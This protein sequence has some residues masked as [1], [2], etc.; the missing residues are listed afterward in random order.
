[1]SLKDTPQTLLVT[2]GS[3]FRKR[4]G[5]FDPAWALLSQAQQPM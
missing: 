3:T 2:G 1:M 5:P 4:P